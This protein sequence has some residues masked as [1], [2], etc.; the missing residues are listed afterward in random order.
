MTDKVTV[1]LHFEQG[2]E[3]TPKVEFSYPENGTTPALAISRALQ[4]VAASMPPNLPGEMPPGEHVG[5]LTIR[6]TQNTF[7]KGLGV[8]INIPDPSRLHTA[9]LG[10]L[11]VEIGAGL[12]Q[13]GRRP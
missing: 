7:S 9:D 11:L 8:D 4:R 5:T 1:T 6:R 10:K 3:G 13:E 2:K 12:Q